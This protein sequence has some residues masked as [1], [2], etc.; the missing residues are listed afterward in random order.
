MHPLP[1]FMGQG[2]SWDADG[3]L[4]NKEIPNYKEKQN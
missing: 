2:R 1:N 3:F 4:T